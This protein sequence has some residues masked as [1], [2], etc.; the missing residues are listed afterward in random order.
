[1]T[2]YR[3][4]GTLSDIPNYA[5]YL[6]TINALRERYANT[7]LRGRFIDED[8][9]TWDQ[10]QVRVKAF[11]AEDGEIGC[12]LWNPTKEDV[13]V[14]VTFANSASATVFVPAERVSA[15][16]SRDAARES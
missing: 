11:A 5:A 1:M 2:I 10:P 7:L 13:P 3:C 12:A 9:I 14:T 4:C 16:S 8:G 6:K 15:L